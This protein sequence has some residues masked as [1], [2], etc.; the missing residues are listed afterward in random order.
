M[1]SYLL[2]SRDVP[3][4]A[5]PCLSL[6]AVETRFGSGNRRVLRTAV[7]TVGSNFKHIIGRDVRGIH[8]SI[9]RLD[10]S[11]EVHVRRQY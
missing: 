8:G 6:P 10:R 4:A 3:S 9:E 1:R 7:R 2:D 5:E 11:R